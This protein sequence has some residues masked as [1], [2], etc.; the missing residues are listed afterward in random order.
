MAKR[1]SK[2]NAKKKE[3]KPTAAQVNSGKEFV[4][5]RA[6]N[7]VLV[8]R[9]DHPERLPR[10]AQQWNYILRARARWASDP[11][12][13][14]TIGDRAIEDLN[15][16]GVHRDFLRQLA[17]V[18]RIEVEL[19]DWDRSDADATRIHEAAAEFPWEYL[20]SAA[21]RSEGRFQSLLITRLFRNGS[22]AVIPR[23][24]EQVL[25]VESAPGRLKD[26]YVFGDEEDRIRA[27]VGATGPFED[28]MLIKKT[29]QIVELREE[30]KKAKWDAIHVT[31]IDAH[32][33]GWFV[34]E[35]YDVFSKEKQAI[36]NEISTASGRLLD[37]MVLR[38]AG[39]IE[40]PVRYDGPNG[41]ADI[42][43]SSRKPPYVATLNLFY[44]GAHT[45]RELVARGAHAALGF[46]DEIDDE[47]CELFFQA[48]YWAW[49]RPQ[50]DG[51]PL[52]IPE[53]FQAA[54]EKMPSTDRLHGTSIVIW[55]GRSIFDQPHTSSSSK[56]VRSKT[57]TV[58]TKKLEIEKQ[59]ERRLAHLERL[60][61][62][63]IDK[64]ILVDLGIGAEVNYSLLHN[65]RQL[66]SKLTLTKLV[67]GPLEDIAVH[68]E[69]YVGAES[70]PYRQTIEVLNEVQLAL[71]SQVMIPLTASLSRALRERV[72]STVY[73][74]VTCGGRTACE[75]TRRVTLIPVDEWLDDT[76]N[77]P[78][79]PSFV[80]PRDPA[81]LKIIN[82]ARRYLIGIADDLGAGFDG[83]Q[84]EDPDAVDKQVQS[85]WTALVSEYRFQ[86]INP[87]PAYSNKTQRLR[88][89]SEIVG[90]NS[91]TCVD[92]A[93]LLASCLEYVGIYPVLVLLTGHA[94]VGYWRSDTVH[95]EVFA[96]VQKVPATVPAVG[97]KVARDAGLP[98]VDR[99]G[100]RLTTLNYA[101]VMAYVMSGELVMLEAT[102]LTNGS[103]FSDAK[104]EGR[105][106]LRSRKEF[107][108]LL[109]VQLARAASPPVTPLPIIHA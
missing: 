44:S 102:F 27:A 45:A 60:R 91:G 35:F 68:V 11:D 37:G 93:L 84:Q 58:R 50:K 85:V 22:P 89:P 24:P 42:L 33:A 71:A 5:I 25:F 4:T 31:G 82:T 19:H 95:D 47:L 99:Y 86:Y 56:N 70:Y 30:V 46:L 21:T 13:R 57:A 14:S 48:F 97:D 29:S 16:I 100:W 17:L 8:A 88:T 51:S 106:N 6:Q 83:Y 77:N 64:L 104:T 18:D 28:D 38:E 109:D 63:A 61:R 7:G 12:L 43:V 1:P 20:I 80:L 72:Q 26:T 92:L 65:S 75:E 54:W 69:L 39:E 76:E 2:R 90:S 66:L 40:R 23:P 9:P 107:D 10:L 98:Y 105:A 81:I 78:W 87:P 55:M 73:V 41:L 32:Q 36:W 62:T 101:E 53:A 67:E 94:F 103:S 52:T 59:R 15:S 79:L 96:T 49:C 108:S 34:K 74:K 3:S